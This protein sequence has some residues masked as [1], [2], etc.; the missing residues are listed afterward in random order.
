MPLRAGSSVDR[1]SNARQVH[2]RLIQTRAAE[3]EKAQ[4]PGAAAEKCPMPSLPVVD[5]EDAIMFQ[6]VCNRVAVVD[7][8]GCTPFMRCV[9]TP[10]VA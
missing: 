8:P 7:S 5:Y 6:G 10:F 9:G 3:T 2:P 1:K 4:A